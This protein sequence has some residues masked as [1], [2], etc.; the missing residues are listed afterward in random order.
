[1]IQVFIPLMCVIAMAGSNDLYPS[2]TYK[3][4]IGCENVITY[5]PVIFDYDGEPVQNTFSYSFQDDFEKL[6]LY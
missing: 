3:A 1:M 6:Y 2:Y 4:N 5:N